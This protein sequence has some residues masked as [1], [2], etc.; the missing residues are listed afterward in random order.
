MLVYYV[1]I[2]LYLGDFAAHLIIPKYN[3][4]PIDSVD[5]LW[6]ET[7][8]KWVAGYEREAE[9]WEWYFNHVSDIKERRFNYTAKG[10]EPLPAQAIRAL[11]SNPDD[12]VYLG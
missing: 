1:L 2:N 4:P 8:F 5:Q 7:K 6:M 3:T 12:L 9:T 10:D 11:V